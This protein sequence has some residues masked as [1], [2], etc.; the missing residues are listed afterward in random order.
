MILKRVSRQ[1]KG[2]KAAF[3]LTKTIERKT[4]QPAV[5]GCTDAEPR[6]YGRDSG[7]LNDERRG[8]AAPQSLR[9]TMTS[10][11]PRVNRDDSSGICAF[12]YDVQKW[13]RSFQQERESCED[14]PRP[15]R[16]VTL[17]TEENVQKIEKFVLVYRK[18]KLWQI[19][20]SIEDGGRKPF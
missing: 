13:A 2:E 16:L 5:V 14:D 20:E 4:I 3:V 6:S 8:W 18:I 19:A 7:I 9:S 15:G 17:V 12:V 10:A 11:R 1:N